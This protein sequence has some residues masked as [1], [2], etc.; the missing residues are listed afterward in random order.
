MM[1]GSLPFHGLQGLGLLGEVKI[2]YNCNTSSA[3]VTAG[4]KELQITTGVGVA[5]SIW[6][7]EYKARAFPVIKNANQWWPFCQQSNEIYIKNDLEVL[8]SWGQEYML[9]LD[10]SGVPKW[11]SISGMV[12]TDN[13][14]E[15]GQA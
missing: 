11:H 10:D 14:W 5:L 3:P 1:A 7:G 15:W 8:I 13:E 6:R 2:S 12:H 4:E 9:I